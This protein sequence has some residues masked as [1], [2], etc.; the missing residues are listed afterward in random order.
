MSRRAGARSDPLGDSRMNRS[1]LRAQ[2]RHGAQSPEI[3]SGAVGT[4]GAARP[5]GRCRT[6]IAS[7]WRAL[8]LSGGVRTGFVVPD[9]LKGGVVAPCRYEAAVQRTYA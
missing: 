1:V 3:S 8:E 5:R 4:H 9:Q 2:P 7:H 6:G